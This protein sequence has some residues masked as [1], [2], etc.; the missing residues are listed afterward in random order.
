[1]AFVTDNWLLPTG[2]TNL[3]R[4]IIGSYHFGDEDIFSRTIV[5]AL[6]LVSLRFLQM[7]L[8]PTS[9]LDKVIT[10][11]NQT[12]IPSEHRSSNDDEVP[13]RVPLRNTNLRELSV[14]NTVAPLCSPTFLKSRLFLNL[15]SL[16]VTLYF[17]L[18]T[19][20]NIINCIFLDYVNLKRLELKFGYD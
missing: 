8:G 7:K 9:R 11:L 3:T 1:M 14:Y 4:L 19:N 17:F 13:S 6:Q 18:L 2:L 20:Y 16:Q 15:T 5:I 10:I 12:E